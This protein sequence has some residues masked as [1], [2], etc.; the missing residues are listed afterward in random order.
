M[1]TLDHDHRVLLRKKI[2]QYPHHNSVA[3]LFSHA[4]LMI[5]S[6]VY[7]IKFNIILCTNEYK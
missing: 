3:F 7:A 1:A 4:L 5:I 6:Y 2:I